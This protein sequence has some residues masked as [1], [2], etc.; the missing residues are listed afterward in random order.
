MSLFFRLLLFRID[1]LH[2]Y[3]TSVRVFFKVQLQMM[4]DDLAIRN[5]ERR[6][7]VRSDD[8]DPFDGDG[9]TATAHEDAG[10]L[11][12]RIALREV[13]VS[14]LYG[15]NLTFSYLLMLAVMSY[16]IGLFV[17]IVIGLATGHYA[18]NASLPSSLDSAA[19]GAKSY[20]HTSGGSESSD[21]CH[22]QM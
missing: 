15:I 13:G 11:R 18:F 14:V 16:N 20:R 6:G 8:R 3:L 10:M 19:G 17:I 4:K 2:E 5:Q 21:V 22:S 7:L 12:R 9:E 1:S